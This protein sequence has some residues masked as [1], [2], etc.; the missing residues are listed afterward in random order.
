MKNWFDGKILKNLDAG[1]SV[2]SHTL[3]YGTGVFEGIRSYKTVT[4]Y[5]VFRLEEHIDR[6][7]RSAKSLRIQIPY[8][9]RELCE[10]VHHVLKENHLSDAYIRPLVFLGEGNMGLDVGAPGKPNPVHVMISAWKWDSY[11]KN[12]A[13]AG[14]HATISNYRRVFS[15]STLVQA[16]ANGHYLNSYCAHM[17]AKALGYDEA[18]LMDADGFL[19]EASASNLF[20][21]KNGTIYTP[22]LTSALAGITRDTVITLCREESYPVVESCITVKDVMSSDEIFLTGTACEVSPVI[23]IDGLPV[24]TGI[25]GT[26]TKMLSSRYQETVRNNHYKHLGH[27]KP[28]ELKQSDRLITSTLI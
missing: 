11:F 3:H 23:S 19:A 28:S 22:L 17:A 20:I 18:L 2:M 7:I 26:I 21:V 15:D 25:V 9:V 4:G 12:S 5:N 1:I 14:I 27:K 6:L 10:A 8:T 13:L 16:K 24:G